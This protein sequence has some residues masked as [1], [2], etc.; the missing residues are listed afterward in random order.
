VQLIRRPSPPRSA[1]AGYRFPPEV[2]VL[3]VGCVSR[4]R[5]RPTALFCPS[6]VPHRHFGRRGAGRHGAKDH[7]RR[8]FRLWMP[9][10]M[11]FPP[12]GAQPNT[13]PRSRGAGGGRIDSVG[14]GNSRGS[15]L[16][17]RVVS[18]QQTRATFPH[19]FHAH[20]E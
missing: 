4:S 13:S 18:D 20:V 2:I 14:R 6:S 15:L 8:A 9:T 10:G 7:R 3:A 16:A 19:P 12:I 17:Y 11:G 5:R 1:F